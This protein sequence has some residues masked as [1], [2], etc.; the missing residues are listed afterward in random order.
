[1]FVGNEGMI[2]GTTLCPHCDTRFKITGAQLNAHQGMVRCGHCLHVFDAHL[3]F[4]PGPPD[5]Q[6]ELPMPEVSTAEE[7]EAAPADEPQAYAAAQPVEPSEP[8]EP[9]EAVEAETAPAPEV[10]ETADN[11]TGEPA[12]LVQEAAPDLVDA[13][14]TTEDETEPEERPLP[15]QEA[16]AGE[17]PLPAAQPMTLAEQVVIVHDETDKS[18]AKPVR[19]LWPWMIAATLLLMLLFAQAAYFF[20]VDLAARHPEWKPMLVAYCQML[21]CDIP[22]PQEIG[23]ISIESSSLEAAPAHADR[24]I[25]NALLRNHAAYAQAFPHLELTLNDAQDKPLARR[26]F[27]PRDYLPPLES[28]ETGLQANHELGAKLL[29]DTDD[30]KPSGYRLVLLYPE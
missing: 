2:D 8:V 20:R 5:P 9:V 7:T 26:V 16:E 4:I 28:E 23:Q 29:L 14:A 24:I 18:E 1:M 21:D 11:V 17:T 12:E 25:L 22:L 13:A 15:E 10:A 19:R 3:S 30:L 27:H 6:L